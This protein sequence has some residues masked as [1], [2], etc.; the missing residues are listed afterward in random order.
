MALSPDGRL[1]YAAD[2]YH[3][4][5][6]VI[7][8]QSGMVIERFKTGRR[9]YRILFHPDGKIVLRHPLGR[10]HPGPLRRRQ[11]QPARPTVRVGAHPSDMVWR[12]GATGDRRRAKRR[13]RRAPLRRRRQHQSTSIAVGVTAAKECNVVESIN[14]AMTPRQ[15]LGMTPSALALSADG[16]RLFVACSDANAVAVVDIAD[17]AQP[18]A[19]LHPHRLVSHRGARAAPTA[20]WW[21]STARGCAPIP[22]RRTAPI[23]SKRPNPV[24]A[25]EPAPPACST[26]PHP[27]RHGVVDRAVHRRATRRLDRDATLANSPYRDAKLDADRARCPK[28]EHVIYIVKENRT[29]DQVLGDMKQ[30]NGDPSLVLFGENVTPNHHKLA[31]EFVLLD[32]FYVNSRCQRRRPQLV[33]RGHRAGLRAEDVAQQYAGRRKHLRLRRAGPSVAAARRLSLDQ[34]RRSRRLHPQLRL[35]GQQQA[36]RRRP[37]PSRSPACAT[38]CWPRSPTRSYRGFDL[39][40]PDVER[41]KVF[42]DELAEYEKTGKMPRLIVMRL[43]NDHTSGTAA[44]KIAP[45]SAVADNDYALGMIVEGV[46]KSRFWASTAIFV[47]EDDAQNGPD[48]VDSH[49]SPA[50]VISPCKRRAVDSTHVQHHVDAAHHGIA[51]GPAAHDAL[52][53]RRAAHDRR[54]PEPAQPGPVRRREAAHSAGRAQPRRRARRRAAP[55]HELRGGRRESTTTS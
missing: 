41:A 5:V 16:K 1:I 15:P 29:Y 33:H 28:I 46:S 3:D 26:W 11:R 19:R 54:L 36:Q 17:G 27:D 12:A 24:H 42:L 39:D 55:P 7:N 38:R 23:P 35:H 49:R 4:S 40:Y 9:P 2:L 34:R 53:R 43:G 10:R 6:V 18:R 51:P 48:H 45:L 21:C 8:P 22:T 44:G 31:R 50:F 13:L 37:A 20:R 52:R 47:L 30:G 14:I 25:G 32:N